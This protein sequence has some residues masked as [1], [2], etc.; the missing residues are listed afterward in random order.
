MMTIRTNRKAD[1]RQ[2]SFYPTN[3]MIEKLDGLCV[4]EGVKSRA[5]ILEMILED[6]FEIKSKDIRLSEELTSSSDSFDQTL[7]SQQQ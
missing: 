4:S 2:I 7:S 3:E 6:W 1:R 5:Y